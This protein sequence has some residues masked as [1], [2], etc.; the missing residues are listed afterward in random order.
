MTSGTKT[1]DGRYSISI[2]QKTSCFSPATIV[3]GT[4]GTYSTKTWSGG[5]AAKLP[6]V[7]GA[8]IGY[9]YLVPVYRFRKGKMYISH[10]RE[11]RAFIR[12]RSFRS[13]M[14]GDHPYTMTSRRQN[15]DVYQRVF[16][17]S[18]GSRTVENTSEGFLP[19]GGT[20]RWNA[21]DDIALMGKLR[22]RIQGE[23][24]NLAVFLAEGKESLATVMDSAGRIYRS[25]RALKR[26]NP[27]LAFRELVEGR[28]KGRPMPKNLKP[29]SRE[30]VTQEWMSSNWLQLQYGWKP[31]VQDAYG[32]AAHLAYMQNRPRTRTYRASRTVQGTVTPYVSAYKPTTAE[33]YT[34]KSIIAKVTHV[35]EAALVGL[36]DPA[37]LAWELLPF[38][39]VIDWFAPIGNYLSALNLNRALTGTYVTS[40]KVYSFYSGLV[41]GVDVGGGILSGGKGTMC[42]TV[43]F[44]RTVASSLPKVDF[45]TLKGYDKVATWL[46][47]SNAIALLASI[48]VPR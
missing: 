29:V 14:M 4:V 15:S 19:A 24:F 40:T 10:Y 9:T 44:T 1:Q 34:R 5:D 7:V 25:L 17:C 12:P 16:P 37:S 31:L 21:N 32:A 46:H 41:Q 36:Q 6:N 42:E 20:Q 2:S 26:G 35:N 43:S 28:P 30:L 22:S 13:S 11:K 45:P 18:P 48:K 23:D 39:F 47:A 3:S 38:S 33:V 27:V 8:F